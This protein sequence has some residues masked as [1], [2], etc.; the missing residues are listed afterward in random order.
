M[1]ELIPEDAIIVSGGSVGTDTIAEVYANSE[2]HPYESY[3]IDWNIYGKSAAYVRNT[4]MFNICSYAIFFWDG[5]NENTKKMIDYYPKHKRKPRI[6]KYTEDCLIKHHTNRV[7][8][9]SKT[10]KFD[11]YC[12]RPS[13]FGNP[14]VLTDWSKRE[15]VIHQYAAYLL[16]TEKLLQAIVDLPKDTVLGCHCAP[17]LCHC[18]VILWLVDNAKDELEFI[19]SRLKEENKS[20]LP[21]TK[22]PPQSNGFDASRRE[23]FKTPGR[24]YTHAGLQVAEGWDQIVQDGWL[25]LV[26]I[27]DNKIIKK[28]L[29]LSKQMVDLISEQDDNVVSVIYHTNEMKGVRVTNRRV[30]FM[31]D[32]YKEGYWYVDIRDVVNK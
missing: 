25:T 29:H 27:P 24:L 2:L 30:S 3:P 19:L 10:K 5:V 21:S 9:I 26:E 8:N 22:K 4:E 7:V 1:K 32:I 11:V 16:R 12:G 18:D 23:E 17:F 31:D 13:I 20:K 15:Y 14:H 6:I 28:N